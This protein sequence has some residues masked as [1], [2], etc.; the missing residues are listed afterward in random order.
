MS[1]RKTVFLEMQ[2]AFMS[3]KEAKDFSKF[4]EAA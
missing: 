3:S 4:T 1:K 2:S